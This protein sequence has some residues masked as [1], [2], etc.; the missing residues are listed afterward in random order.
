MRSF[1]KIFF[2]SLLAMAVFLVIGFFILVAMMGALVSGLTSSDDV[3]TGSKAVLV[4]DL[5]QSYQEQTRE[6]PIASFSSGDQYDYP[7]LYDVIRIIR[8]AKS[9]SSVKGIYIKC[10]DNG[11]GFATSEELRNAL[12]DFKKSKKFIY[13]YG[14]IIPQRAYYIGNIA[15][16]IYCNPKG[17]VEWKGYALQYVFFKEALDRLDIKPQIFYAGKFKSAT[18]PFREEKMTEPNK[19]QSLEFLSFL[20]NELLLTTSA[21]R[22]IDTASLHSYANNYLIRTATDAVKYKLID[23]A[24]YDDEVQQEI[25]Q[26]LKL[27]KDARINFVPMGKYAKSVNYKA[28][29][30]KDRIALIY[31]QGDIVDGKGD[32][33]QIGS[34]TY[35]GLI[36]K[37]RLD[38]DVKAIVLRVNSGGGSGLASENIWRELSITRKEKPV[39]LSF[40]DYAASGGYYLACNADSIFAQPNTLTG[41]IGVFS[42]IPNMEGFFKNKLGVTFDG[43]KTAEHADALTATKPLSETERAFIQNDVDSFYQTF[44]TRV[45]NGRKLTL[46][47]VDSIGQGRVWMGEKALKLGLVDKLGSLQ[48]AVDCAAR[49][50]KTKEYR[51]R[52][53]PE[54]QSFLD[55]LL[56]NYKKVAKADA[57]KEELGTTGFKIYNSLKRIQGMIGST[58]A[59]MVFDY[60]IK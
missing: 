14:D 60:S 7:G 46:A 38:K 4:V 12:L 22:G 31:A 20:Y 11:N 28:G 8:F 53:Y 27:E 3:A 15:D 52:E 21:T 59:R 5:G 1:F 33:D 2:A 40:G 32:M 13:A 55:L 24:R 42:I 34:E 37:A 18:E 23:G 9:D 36:R 51:L 35:R 57:I 19:V 25:K 47:M 44:L 17:G 54:P 45:A 49:M 41:S 48:D 10:N 43:V 26:N 6:N 29:K 50:G 58:Q 30:G 39:I 16:K 56:G